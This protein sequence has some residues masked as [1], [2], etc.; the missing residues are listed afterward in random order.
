MSIFKTLSRIFRE[1]PMADLT[2]DWNGDTIRFSDW[3]NDAYGT[4]QY[5]TRDRRFEFVFD[6]QPVDDQVRVY[7]VDQPSYQG[8]S[9][10]GH[11][12]HRK[13]D[14]DKGLHYVSI[15]DRM[16]PTNVPH[17]LTW[18]VSW[19]EHTGNYIRTGRHFA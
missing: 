4:F 17:A 6:L 3:D 19:A 12:T 11:D 1:A 13:Y 8:R 2:Y 7:I 18:A 10:D 9:E 16:S 14:S 5:T 15:E